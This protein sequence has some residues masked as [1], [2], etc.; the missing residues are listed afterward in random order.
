MANYAVWNNRRRHEWLTKPLKGQY[1][2][3]R[4]RE[5]CG[6]QEAMD[7]KAGVDTSAADDSSAE[8]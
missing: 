6:L 5:R 3:K 7:R 4:E 8:S 1:L 2:S